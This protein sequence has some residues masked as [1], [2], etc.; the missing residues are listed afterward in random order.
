MQDDEKEVVT[1]DDF[2]SLLNEDV[3]ENDTARKGGNAAVGG[4]T[5]YE[6]YN[7]TFE[8]DEQHNTYMMTPEKK[9]FKSDEVDS[10]DKSD[11]VDSPDVTY[12]SEFLRT[13]PRRQLT[14]KTM[15]KYMICGMSLGLRKPQWINVSRQVVPQGLVLIQLQKRGNGRVN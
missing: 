15:R 8:V 1:D 11:K 6:D 14:T 13:P 4:D 7:Q 2:F 10:P 5:N 3:L 9:H 12:L